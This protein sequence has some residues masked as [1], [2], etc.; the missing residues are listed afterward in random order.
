[1]HSRVRIPIV[2]KNKQVVKL[3]RLSENYK[4]IELKANPSAFGLIQ[5]FQGIN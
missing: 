4:F 1:V 3:L 2:I 5:D